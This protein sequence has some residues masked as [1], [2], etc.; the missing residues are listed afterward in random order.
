[1]WRR[2]G[3]GFERERERKRESYN[4]IGFDNASRSLERGGKDRKRRAGDR[5]RGKQIK[6]E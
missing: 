3:G 1:M 2:R 5:E 4:G 6:A